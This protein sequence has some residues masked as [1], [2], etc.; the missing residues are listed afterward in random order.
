MS[1]NKYPGPY[2]PPPTGSNPP[3]SH[4]FASQ[5]YQAYQAPENVIHR[6]QTMEG[7]GTGQA[8]YGNGPNIEIGIDL[9]LSPDLQ[10]PGH[11][12][13][14]SS[15]T[16][17]SQASSGCRNS[18]TSTD[19]G[20]GSSIS[21]SS[22][23]RPT[24]TYG[25][26]HRL[27]N[28]SSSQSSV[29]SS[30]GSSRQSHH[31]SS[32]SIQDRPEDRIFSLNIHDM[33]SNGVPD[34]DILIAWLTDLHFEEYFNLFVSAGYDMP[35][36]SRMTPEDL[37]AIGIQNPAH[38]KKLKSEI[39]KLNISDGLPN[40]IPG[41]LEEWLRLLRLEEYGP[42]L[43]S[44]GYA[45]VQEVA[46]ISIEDLEDTGFYRLGH[47][48]RLV[49]GIRKVK[50]LSR[51]RTPAY[52]YYQQQQ[53]FQMQ[54]QEIPLPSVQ[55]LNIKTGGFSSFQQTSQQQQS[56]PFPSRK[57]PDFQPQLSYSPELI[58]INQY[59][60]SRQYA[61]SHSEDLPLPMP[62]PM[63][64]L[65]YPLYKQS[66]GAPYPGSPR[67]TPRASGGLGHPPEPS[68]Y[69]MMRSYDDADILRRSDNSILVHDIP[70]QSA[71]HPTGGETLPR[72]KGTIKP[73]PVAKII[74][75]TRNTMQLNQDE[76]QSWEEKAD[77]IQICDN[78]GSLLCKSGTSSPNMTLR[79]NRSGSDAGIQF[80]PNWQEQ[81]SNCPTS[82]QKMKRN[83]SFGSE[84]GLPFANDN[85]GTIRMRS[86]SHIILPERHQQL[87][88]TPGT[89]QK[90]SAGDVLQ[91]IG[92]MLSDLTDELDA[93]LK[94][95]K[96]DQ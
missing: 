16:I 58:Q 68:S 53:Q 60:R 48:K 96:E 49:L 15:V 41:S 91:D 23:T 69:R 8:L 84:S 32:S 90:R 4:H 65:Q 26:Q 79:K 75:N 6:G 83:S 67:F 57:L 33:I 63:P 45:T 80:R 76:I 40:H 56:S 88:E 85:A 46:T 17:G 24:N 43:M 86:N 5:G 74:A 28:V 2:L 89:S 38:R 59:P 19:S 37:T 35:T 66:L 77:E 61:H 71:K 92:S 27:S 39:S 14:S 44:Q 20:R 36:I 10:S 52:D 29:C 31:S 3:Q 82:T 62:E 93:M 7:G 87:Q 11:D 81:V 34:E 73:K 12:S 72:L 18:T 78:N 13:V 47:Q 64:P 30:L 42:S 70:N 55:T 25:H 21:T 9:P 54:N 50:D 94:L 1:N 51:N 95:D 22:T